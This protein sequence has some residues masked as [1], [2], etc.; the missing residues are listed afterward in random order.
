MKVQLKQSPVQFDTDKHEYW[1]YGKQLKGI[2]STLIKRAFP[3][4]YKDI[5]PEVLAA[6]ARKGKDL[7][8]AI[9]YHDHFGGEPQDPRIA[10]YERIK[11]ENNL[12]T[13]ENEYLVSD[14]KEY[15][16]SIDLVMQD[17]DGAI[18]IADTKTT[19]NL[20]K[21]SVALQLSIYKR[22]FEAMNPEIK[23]QKLYVIW[24]PNKDTTIGEIHELTPVSDKQIDEL[25]EADRYGLPY[26]YEVQ[27]DNWE[28]LCSQLSVWT[29]KKAEAEEKLAEIR[30]QMLTA[31]Q[32]NNL[33]TVRS[34]HYT[35]TLIEAKTSQRFD[36]AKF[37][38]ENKAMYD[39]YTKT[40]ETPSQLRI[41]PRNNNQ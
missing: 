13:I 38:Q 36:S 35:V 9:E 10:L 6:A 34:D 32:E 19:W 40:V 26:Q 5:D 22:F 16:S 29:A 21:A 41:L 20:D 7:H 23:V 15:A 4:K 39:Y 37:K 17:Q 11:T 8:E 27:P 2:T 31:M 18:C 1:I 33:Q 24:L 30:E 28:Q 3:D 12:T 14:E 25:I